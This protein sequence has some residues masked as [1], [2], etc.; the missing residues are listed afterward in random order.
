MFGLTCLCNDGIHMEFV[1]WNFLSL[2]FK[3]MEQ[4]EEGTP[5]RKAL[6]VS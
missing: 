1:A 4:F 2:F 3:G 5:A 6:Q